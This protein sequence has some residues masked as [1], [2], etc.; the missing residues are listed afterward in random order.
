[1][2]LISSG[3]FPS[4]V[5]LSTRYNISAQ[6]KA[7]HWYLLI[8]TLKRGKSM[9]PEDWAGNDRGEMHRGGGNR[10][11]CHGQRKQA[12]RIV[13]D[14]PMTWHIKSHLENAVVRHTGVRPRR[15]F[16]VRAVLPTR[17][18]PA[19]ASVSQWKD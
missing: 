7:V 14:F 3:Y 16:T 9:C 1:M 8:C 11:S 10:Y 13:H 15:L 18:A 4:P 12:Q 17:G 19:P 6:N 5:Y 2:H